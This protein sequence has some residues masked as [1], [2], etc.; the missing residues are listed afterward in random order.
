MTVRPGTPKVRAVIFDFGGVIS[1]FDVSI[2]F[3]R[4]LGRTGRGVE[5]AGMLVLQSGLPRS[6]ESGRITSRQF[7]EGMSALCGVEVPE[8]EFVSAFVSIFTPI[9]TTIRLIRDLSPSYRLGLLS[10][11]NEWHFEHHI[12]SVEIFPLFDAVTLSYRVRA[13]KP[14]GEIYRDSLRQLGLP[15]ECRFP[16]SS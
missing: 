1:S 8:E 13:M 4:I 6:Y 5:E 16:R 2:F 12:R 11:T 7:Y 9:G 14:A 10:N 15:P 3:R